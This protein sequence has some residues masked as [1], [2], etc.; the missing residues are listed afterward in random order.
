MSRDEVLDA[1][2]RWMDGLWDEEA[3]LLWSVRRD[4]HMTRE[5][6]WYAL[7]L[8]HQGR[9]ERA[10]AAL[11][12]VCGQQFVAPGTDF[13]GTW[14][15]APEEADPPDEPVMWFHYDPNWRQFIGTTFAVI[16]DRYPDALPAAT[17][18]RLRTAIERAVNGEPTGR[19]EPNYANIALMKAWLD[20]WSGHT[21]RAETF[22]LATFAAFDE[23]GAFL[24]YNS[25]TYYGID[26]WAL[27]LWRNSTEV[28][29]TLGA[30]MEASLWRDTAR[31]YHAG[32]RNVCG[33]HDRSYG[34][35]MTTH[36]TPLGLWIWSAV[37]SALAPF[38]DPAQRFHHPHDFCFGP[39]VAAFDANVPNDALPHLRAFEGER[40]VEQVVTSEPSRVAT[41][42]LGE[43][44]MLG[45]WTGP[46]S[47]IG[48]LQHHHATAHW[49]RP[50]GGVGWARLMPEV[51]AAAR[52]MDAKLSITSHTSDPVV[53]EVHPAPHAGPQGWSVEGRRFDVETEAVLTGVDGS[54]L[55]YAPGGGLTSMVISPL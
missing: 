39:C 32:L 17:V 16:C 6:A 44:V 28:L 42:W 24:E 30:Q 53:F 50:D 37:G 40:V 13:D 7:G 10:A 21:E 1:S 8:L 5:T 55:S 11:D 41:A 18:G 22:A 29:R 49:R 2:M 15:R 46:A 34:M 31:F 14:R 33:P 25:P 12:A 43:D 4:R 19:V 26:L 20:A 51:Q 47:G 36:A 38:P 27:A 48:W 35:D 45:G 3:S 52:I 9:P 54:T 23:H